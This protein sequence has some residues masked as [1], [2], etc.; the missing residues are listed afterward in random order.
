V[1]R[2]VVALAL[3]AFLANLPLVH[4]TLTG[5]AVGPVVAVTLLADAGL[6][7]AALLLLRY[8]GRDRTPE[9]PP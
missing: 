4:G 1:S 5:Q 6:I 2:H 8:G 7:A 9:P 3:A